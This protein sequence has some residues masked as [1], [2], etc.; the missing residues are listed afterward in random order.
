[1]YSYRPSAE[2]GY[3]RILR[4]S[5]IS[6][7]YSQI[8]GLSF[9]VSFAQKVNILSD[10]LVVAWSGPEVQAKRALRIL[11]D[12]SS[13]QNLTR[14]DIEMELKAIDP[15]GIDKLQLI[16]LLVTDVRGATV[17]AST[18]SWGVPRTDVPR[19]GTVYAAGTGADEFI[20]LLG[21]ADWT[22]GG[23]ANELQVAHLILGELVNMEYRRG[24]TIENRWGGGFEA[25]TFASDLVDFKRSATSFTPFG[26][27]TC[28]HQ[29]RLNSFQCIIRQPIGE[30]R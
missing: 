5:V 29:T 10:R 4:S 12:V 30:T 27:W 18:F 1:M 2:L 11:A 14:T 15:D 24:G 19:L 22:L 6:I 28:V 8:G 13:R 26:K 16:G 3:G 20:L 17:A 25:V 21:E 7:E 23:T 9:E